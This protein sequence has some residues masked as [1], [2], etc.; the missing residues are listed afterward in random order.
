LRKIVPGKEVLIET[1]P[2]YL[3]KH[4]INTPVFALDAATKEIVVMAD[5]AKEMVAEAADGF[6]NSNEKALKNL[7]KREEALDN[8][9]EAVTDYLTSLTQRDLSEEESRRIPALLH[10]VNDIERIGDHSENL[11]ELAI[12]RIEGNL[13]FTKDSYR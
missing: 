13:P 2:K 7:P 4:L 6:I 10:S 11:M 8:L 9:Q 3:E 5:H 12:R 1:G